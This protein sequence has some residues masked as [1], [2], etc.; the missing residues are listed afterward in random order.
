MGS[1]KKA[2]Y[3]EIC[4]RE[5]SEHAVFKIYVEGSEFTVCP[6]CYSK[7]I[8]GR[9]RNSQQR[10]STSSLQSSNISNIRRTTTSTP[11]RTSTS[12]KIIEKYEIDPMFPEIIRRAREKKGLT[13]KDLALK[14][15]ESENVI[16]RIESGRLTPTIELARRIE[17]ILGVKILVP[18]VEEKE[19]PESTKK[20]LREDLTLGDLATLKKK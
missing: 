8:M 17:D 1:S 9:S 18:R 12:S 2:V 7:H 15:R 11:R 14:L 20:D 5:I 4:G 6:E 3:C 13:T 10:A 16:K 19:I